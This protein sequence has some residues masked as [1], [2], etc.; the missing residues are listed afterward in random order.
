MA[1]MMGDSRKI[2]DPLLSKSAMFRSNI[3]DD[4]PWG[5]YGVQSQTSSLDLPTYP[6]RPTVTIGFI[7]AYEQLD[8]LSSNPSVDFSIKVHASRT[9]WQPVIRSLGQ[10]SNVRGVSGTYSMAELSEF[11]HVDEVS[12][13]DNFEGF[14]AQ[15]L[16]A[17]RYLHTTQPLLSMDINALESLEF[18]SI[19]G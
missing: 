17:L 7:D 4:G 3:L 6:Y 9:P 16:P 11:V 18:L 14:A 8:F 19:Y 5:D 15:D 1:L 10:L 12:I 2:L 13:G